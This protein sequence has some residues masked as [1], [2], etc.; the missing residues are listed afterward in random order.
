MV[1]RLFTPPILLP[2][3]KHMRGWK[4]DKTVPISVLLMIIVQLVMLIYWASYLSARVDYT[5][6]AVSTLPKI[7]EQL[8]R[9]EERV[10]GLREEMKR[11]K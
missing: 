1:L 6:R 2:M 10:E 7:S 4:L 5:E 3:T 8:A 11:R 9:I